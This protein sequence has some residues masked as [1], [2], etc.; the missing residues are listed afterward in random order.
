[1]KS[2]NEFM[3][4]EIGDSTKAVKYNLMIPPFADEM[5][6]GWFNI[7]NKVS[8]QVQMVPKGTMRFS[9]YE[10]LF[11]ANG[12]SVTSDAGLYYA[13]KAIATIIAMVKE[14]VQ[15]K[16]EMN[17]PVDF[18]KFEGSAV[19]KD[20]ERNS[21]NKK[22]IQRLK[23]YN[24]FVKKAISGTGWKATFTRSET[25]IKIP[26]KLDWRKRERLT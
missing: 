9:G 3:L 12:S 21:S 23:L 6:V 7:D 19:L 11:S 5:V 26:N 25:K 17:D 2:L 20:E 24:A 16:K 18:I 10:I 1:M 8:Y 4:V 14:V 22:Y 13:F 15:K